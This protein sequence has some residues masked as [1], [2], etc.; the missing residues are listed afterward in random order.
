[1]DKVFKPSDSKT[2]VYI[3]T[4]KWALR[5][6]WRHQ[7]WVKMQLYALDILSIQVC[8]WLCFMF[9]KCLKCFNCSVVCNATFLDVIC[10][11]Y[12]H[13]FGIIFFKVLHLI[14][15]RSYLL[16]QSL[17]FSQSQSYYDQ[18]QSAS[19]S[20]RQAPIWDPRPIVPIL[21]LII[22]LDSFGFVDVGRPLWREVGSVI[23][24]FCWASP[25]QPFS[26]LSP[27]GL[28]SIVYRL[29]ILDSPNQQGQV[30]VLIS[31]RNRVAQLYPRALGLSN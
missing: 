15:T 23:F 24:S 21:C 12:T 17:K 2:N 26:D 10:I 20:W 1:M 8:R 18:R 30:P 28:M 11:W 31:P 13:K 9:Y 29:Y 3:S 27:T 4:H 16:G 5:Y 25:E 22:F 14:S 6:K 7:I 19:P